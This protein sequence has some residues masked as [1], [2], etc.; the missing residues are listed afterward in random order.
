MTRA[1]ERQ[2]TSRF[3]VMIIYQDIASAYRAFDTCN[4]VSR[5][6]GDDF[7]LNISVWNFQEFESSPTC[8]AALAEALE[9]DMIIVAQNRAPRASAGLYRWLWER[10]PAR[11]H[12]PCALVGLLDPAAPENHQAELHQLLRTVAA[13]AKMDFFSNQSEFPTCSRTYRLPR[14]PRRLA[15]R[16]LRP[17]SPP[18]QLTTAN[19]SRT[20]AGPNAW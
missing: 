7:T 4:L 12:Q 2:R 5:K 11:H 19:R 16:R 17:P 18:R 13:R 14:A 1:F 15:P 3:R 20:S 6:L 10:L 9:T 8:D